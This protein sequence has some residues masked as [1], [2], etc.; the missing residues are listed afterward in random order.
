MNR[1]AGVQ[2]LDTIRASN[3]R[4]EGMRFHRDG[5]WDELD[6]LPLTRARRRLD[7]R[8]HVDARLRA[9][10]SAVNATATKPGL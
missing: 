6:A 10:V 9:A 2:T 3:S 7:R 4:A 5:T 1:L 8:D